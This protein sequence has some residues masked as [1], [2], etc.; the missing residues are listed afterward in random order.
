MGFHTRRVSG[1][2]VRVA[3][4]AAALALCACRSRPEPAHPQRWARAWL[5]S[6]NSQRMEQVGPLFAPRGIYQD[7]L[8]SGPRW[9]AAIA[10][11]WLS[12]WHSYPN[13]RFEAV[14]VTADGDLLIIEWTATGFGA[15]TA[16]QP[17]AGVFLIQLRDS[18]IASVRGYY[19]TRGIPGRLK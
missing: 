15:A 9:G 12:L 14:R 16:A 2:G 13:L 6:L 17:L 3:L 5:E 7:P 8:S 10:Y 19:D 1:R 4:L 11:F 18:A